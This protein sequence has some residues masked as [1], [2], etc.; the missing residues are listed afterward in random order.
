MSYRTD[1]MKPF[2]RVMLVVAATATGCATEKTG[3]LYEV[4]GFPIQSLATIDVPA[5]SSIFSV[6]TL[7]SVCTYDTGECLRPKSESRIAMRPGRKIVHAC[8]VKRGYFARSPECN[9]DLLVFEAES[10]IGYR[11][12]GEWFF[13]NEKGKRTMGPILWIENAAT[14]EVVVRARLVRTD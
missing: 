7:E 12:Y 2:I 4:P 13:K 9:N 10:G 14:G 3:T 11:L 1:Q 5:E 6:V 8:Y